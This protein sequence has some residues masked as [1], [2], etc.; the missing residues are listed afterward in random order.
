MTLKL[1]RG[2]AFSC[3]CRRRFTFKFWT[4]FGEGWES[5][6]H[7]CVMCCEWAGDMPRQLGWAKFA[8]SQIVTSTN[9][10]Q[11][12]LRPRLCSRS[13]KRGTSFPSNPQPGEEGKTV[14]SMLF[15]CA[16]VL[17][18]SFSP[19]RI[20]CGISS[21]WVRTIQSTLQTRRLWGPKRAQGLC[22]GDTGSYL[23]SG[24]LHACSLAP[25]TSRLARRSLSVSGLTLRVLQ[26]GLQHLPGPTWLLP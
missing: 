10:R 24:S 18:F 19:N 12:G 7:N 5:P 15:A 3:P 9:L 2:Q 13:Q 16:H 17:V 14:H 6:M 20:A 25:S 1:E 8:C 4:V 26:N 22:L 21:V 23:A 11:K